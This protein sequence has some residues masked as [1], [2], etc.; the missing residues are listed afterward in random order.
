MVGVDRG[1]QCGGVDEVG[2]RVWRESDFYDNKSFWG[3]GVG[4][5]TAIG[6]GLTAG[7]IL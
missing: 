3:V 4:E 2:E 6:K 1:D 7:L 5:L